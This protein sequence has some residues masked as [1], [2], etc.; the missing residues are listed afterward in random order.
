MQWIDFGAIMASAG[1][2]AQTVPPKGLWDVVTISGV[3]A[4]LLWMVNRVLERAATESKDNQQRFFDEKNE[5]RRMWAEDKV[6]LMKRIDSV[7]AEAQRARDLASAAVDRQVERMQEFVERSLLCQSNTERALGHISQMAD[8]LAMGQT[9]VTGVLKEIIE[10][11]PCLF[12]N[13]HE[14]LKMLEV[15]EQ[16]LSDGMEPDAQPEDRSNVP[17]TEP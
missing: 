10:H 11:R 15:R 6:Q 3:A 7:E 14:L 5:M 16:S 1:A 8:R 17:K 4:V 12:Q 2:L 13:R 9:A